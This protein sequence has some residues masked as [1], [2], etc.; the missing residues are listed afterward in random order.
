MPPRDALGLGAWLLASFA[1]AGVGAV[2]S[3]DAGGFLRAARAAELGAARLVWRARGW[4]YALAFAEILILW[5]L[6]VA[7]VVAF[8]RIR[9]LAG[10]LD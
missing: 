1:A 3:A 2:A 7:T 8:W 9:A 10:A 6:I 4:S 5:A